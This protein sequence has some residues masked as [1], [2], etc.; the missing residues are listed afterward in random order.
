MNIKLLLEHVKNLKSESDIELYANFV[1]VL[2]K[3]TNIPKLLK[4]SEKTHQIIKTLTGKDK[5]LPITSF[6]KKQPLAMPSA[7]FYD[8]VL[9]ERQMLSLNNDNEYVILLATLKMLQDLGVKTNYQEVVKEIMTNYVHK[10]EPVVDDSPFIGR[11]EV[12]GEAIRVLNRSV[13]NNLVI[14]GPGGIGKTTL[15]QKVIEMAKNFKVYA[16]HPG[17][18]QLFD[19]IISLISNT[20]GNRTLFFLDEFTAID[21]QNISYITKNSQVI[22][23]SNDQAYRKFAADFPEIAS[24]FEVIELSEPKAQDIKEILEFQQ[25]R[26]TKLFQVSWENAITDDIYKLAKQYIHQS[27]PA[28]AITLIEESAILAKSKGK[29]TVTRDMVKAIISQKTNIPVGELT[30]FDKKDLSNLPL[31]LKSRIKGQDEAIAKVARVIQRSKLGFKK[32]SG[33]I[34]TFLFVGPSGVGKTELAKAVSEAVFGSEEEMIRL[35]MSEFAEA[36]NVQRLIG[37]PPGYI[38]FEEGGQL[39]NPVRTKPYNLLLLDELEKAH[40][41]V[42]DIFLQVF[43]D[44]RLTDG[45]G[46]V[47]DFRNTV[48]IATS[49]A[50]TD[51]ILDLIEDGKTQSDIETEVK[52]ILPDYFRIEF[53]NRFDQIVVFNQL[54]LNALSQIAVLELKKLKAELAK[55]QIDFTVS[56]K[57]IAKIAGESFDPKYGARELL[58]LIENT[59]ENKLVEMIMSGELKENQLVEF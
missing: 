38:G 7:Q 40:P 43:D 26:L 16:L 51:D 48:I 25:K 22:A 23:T 12:T 6:Y 11:K 19:Q 42:F 18:A 27:F 1:T 46:K 58:R 33:P 15:A 31:K 57:T 17:N 37:A 3:N 55:K 36:H 59:I 53:I 13:R 41:R 8:L 32:K 21:P 50:A 47:V 45:Q 29:T 5:K 24:K 14:V 52:N 10:L 56:D 44:G 4:S 30:E 20:V 49:N 34:G 2:L 54:S 28:K 9:Q 35:D 39:T